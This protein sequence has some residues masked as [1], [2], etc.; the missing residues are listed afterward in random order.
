MPNWCRGVL[1]VKGK[2]D[3]IMR[4]L[5]EGL[6]SMNYG[7]DAIE[8]SIEIVDDCWVDIKGGSF[9]YLKG[10]HRQFIQSNFISCCL[11]DFEE[12][13]EEKVVAIEEMEGA[14]DIDTEGLRALS[15]EFNVDFKVYAFERGMEFNRDVEIQKGKIIKNEVI[16]FENYNW[17]CINP[18][19]GG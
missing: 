12:G 4:F 13:G 7:D 6:V 14:W 3:N 18:N 9:F 10:T 1:K 8:T 5:K 2:Q 15:E 16:R 17:E 11:E 19:L